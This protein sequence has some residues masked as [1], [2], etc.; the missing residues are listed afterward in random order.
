MPRTDLLEDVI[1]CL[2]AHLEIRPKPFSFGQFNSKAPVGKPL[3]FKVAAFQATGAGLRLPR[4]LR[5]GELAT[6][7]KQLSSPD[8]SNFQ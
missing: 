5:S 8:K 6:R 3:T 4:K 1:T 2:P 7:E